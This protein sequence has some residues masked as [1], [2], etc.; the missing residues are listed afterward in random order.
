MRFSIIPG[1]IVT[2]PRL[3]GR[4]LQVLCVLGRHIDRDG[5]CTRSQTKV[6]AEMGCARGTVQNALAR[7]VEIGVVQI[8]PNATAD[9]RDCA[10]DYRVIFDAEAPVLSGENEAIPPCQPVGTPANILAPPA[11]PELAP[12][13]SPELAPYK[14]DPLIT[15]PEEPERERG[16]ADGEGQEA[17]QEAGQAVEAPVAAKT[18]AQR[19]T[20]FW[21]VVKDWPDFAA[22]PKDR[23]RSEWLNLSDAQMDAAGAR[24]DDWFAELKRAKKTHVPAPSTYFREK[25]WE[26]LAAP[27]LSGKPLAGTPIEAPAFGPLWQ[28]AR[29]DWLLAGAGPLPKPTAYQAAVLAAEGNGAA[30]VLRERQAAFGWPQVNRMHE[31]AR[32]GQGLVLSSDEAERLAG[33]VADMVAVPVT[34]ALFNRWCDYHQQ[35]GWPWLPDTG[36]MEVVYF[37]HA[38]IEEIE[39]LRKG[40][41]QKNNHE[42]AA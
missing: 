9:G 21:K 25:L 12:P 26:Y 38:G 4:D 24:R 5:W 42:R 32:H 22:M 15:T 10:H 20:L 6:A 13:A 23:A 8:R 1:W 28:A 37:P 30:D 7:L 27:P 41:D 19:A 40:V 34:S 35:I 31:R 16:R 29:L 17:G 3:I 36:R 14:N 33:R 18:E 11:S 2:D 39:A